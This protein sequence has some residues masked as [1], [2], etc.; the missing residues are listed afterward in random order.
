MASLSNINGL[1][2]VHSTGAIL[3]S[4]SH[5]TS[6][7]R[8]KS[9]GDAAPTWVAA[10]TVIGGPYVPIAGDVTIN[11]YITL[12]AGKILTVGG[13][14]FVTGTSTLTGALSGSTGAF[15]GLVSGITPTAAAN[16]A[17]K[18]Y[19]DNNAGTT[20]TAGN[21]I[22]L[23]GT[24]ATVINADINYISYSGSNNFIVYGAQDGLGTTIPTG[25]II[26]YVPSG[27]TQIVTKAYVSDLPFTNNTGGPFL[28]LAGGA[29][30]GA[31][32][33]TVGTNTTTFST[34]ANQLIIK[35][36]YHASAS[37]LALRSS[38]DTHCMQLYGEAAA[39]GFLASEWGD[40]NIRKVV[41]GG[42]YLNDNN[43][44]FVQ[45]EGTSNM[46]AAAFAGLVSGITPTAAANFAT[47]A[48]VDA[49]PQGDITGLTAGTGITIAAATGP[50]PTITNSAPNIVQ[51]SVTGNAGTATALQTARTINAVSFNGTANI[52]VPSIYDG[53]YRRITNPGG[54]EYV[55]TTS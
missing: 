17:T 16:F 3:F 4:T 10:S 19:V 38:N 37:G 32:S 44:Y 55:T 15:S 13:N 20:Y 34:T 14:L 39:Y 36:S 9:N 12:A 33:I 26:S 22:T 42:L 54:A 29:L 47:K 1:F 7:Q 46:N 48:Y 40:W 50:V 52:M 53:N 6:G 18:D 43:T 49:Q 30:T 24:P 28:P 8:L 23:T 2:D 25:S 45:P 41:S 31:T 21:G 27:G 5:G 11:G 35:N 51:T